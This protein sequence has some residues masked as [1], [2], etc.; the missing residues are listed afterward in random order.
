[1]TYTRNPYPYP[2]GYPYPPIVN[3]GIYAYPPASAYLPYG[4]CGIN[5]Y[6][7]GPYGSCYGGLYRP[8]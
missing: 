6:P 3:N 8:Y 5:P 4:P 2:F 1:M 7:Y